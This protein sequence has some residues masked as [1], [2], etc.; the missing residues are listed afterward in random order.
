MITFYLIIIAGLIKIIAAIIAQRINKKDPDFSEKS[1]KSSI[2]LIKAANY[3]AIGIILLAILLA[4][5]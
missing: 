4:I 2:I 3:F 1:S 5:F